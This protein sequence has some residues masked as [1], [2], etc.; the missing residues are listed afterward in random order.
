MK[1]LSK[2]TP[3]VTV[4]IDLIHWASMPEYDENI[5]GLSV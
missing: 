5:D 4:L 3:T 1:P 2:A